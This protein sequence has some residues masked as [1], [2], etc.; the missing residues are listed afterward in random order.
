MPKCAGPTADAAHA[1]FSNLFIETEFVAQE[2]PSGIVASV[3]EDK[4]IS[5]Y[6]CLGRRG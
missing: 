5:D 4:P 2:T 3:P 6:P 1:A